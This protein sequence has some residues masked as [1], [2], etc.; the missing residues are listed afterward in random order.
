MPDHY[1]FHSKGKESLLWPMRAWTQTQNIDL[2][3]DGY[4]EFY[5]RINKSRNLV[6]NSMVCCSCWFRNS[7][8]GWQI[9][10]Q[11]HCPW[12]VGKLKE[13]QEQWSVSMTSVIVKA[14]AWIC[15]WGFMGH[16]MWWKDKEQV[17]SLTEIKVESRIGKNRKTHGNG[18]T[19]RSLR[20]DKDR[21]KMQVYRRRP[22]H[23]P[24]IQQH[25]DKG[26][27]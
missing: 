5:W 4:N 8:S 25:Y 26:D 24:C 13:G 23:F 11:T 3:T 27:R 15:N 12:D 18:K 2:W 7:D 9:K 14:G 6:G 20:P 19:N 21:T 16:A 22:Y 17:F 1:G 10:K